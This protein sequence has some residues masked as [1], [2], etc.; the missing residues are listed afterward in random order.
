MPG[1]NSQARRWCFT[2][3]NWTPPDVA[4][5]VALAAT[6]TCSYLVFGRET[7]VSG[8]PH[9]QGFVV[10]T[11]PF[12]FTRAKEAIGLTAHVEVTRGTTDQA[13]TYC[14]KDGDYEEYGEIASNQGKRTDWERYRE[15]VVELGR[16]PTERELCASPFLGLYA[17]Y[18]KKLFLIAR[19]LLPPPNLVDPAATP[20]FG[21]QTQAAAIIDG[22]YSERRINFVVDPDGNSGKSWF[23][24]YFMTKRPDDVQV[25]RVGRRD[26]LAYAVDESKTV[27]LFDIPRNQM[28][29][30]QYSVLEMLKD[31]LVFSP[32]Y[33]SGSK[34]MKMNHVM[35]FCNEEPDMD[36]LTNDRYNIIN[37]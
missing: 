14:K 27:F 36:A 13:A 25:L 3:N 18:N 26:D 28:T 11:T 16:V 5:L 24:R 22:D 7:G 10:F 6:D 4:R 8:T 31:L 21:W 30:L 17:R 20:R 34:V 32:K 12:R 23:C 29:F 19:S 35:V 37:V 2:I 15:Y 9:L 1:N 33:E